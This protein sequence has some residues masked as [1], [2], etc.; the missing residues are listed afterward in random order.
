MDAIYSMTEDQAGVKEA[1]EREQAAAARRQ[2]LYHLTIRSL[3]PHSSHFQP[4]PCALDPS[5][6][7]WTLNPAPSTLIPAP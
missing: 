3:H 6:E 1:L 7:P 4:E 5:C 2:S